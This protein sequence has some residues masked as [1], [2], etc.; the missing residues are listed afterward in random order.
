MLHVA[1]DR[2]IRLIILGKKTAH[3]FPAN[4]R[5]DG[6]IT[7]PKITPRKKHKVYRNAPFG[8]D[9]DPNVKPL[10]EVMI[11]KVHSDTLGDVTEEE[12]LEEGFASLDAFKIWWNRRWY[13]D[14]LNYRNHKI[15]PIWVIKFKFLRILPAGKELM[16]RLEE[17][18][19]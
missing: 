17:R 3:R 16:K 18:N 14:G 12:V 9:G 6:Q 13:H 4:Y 11:T 10:A 19:K 5:E 1:D 2:L 15:H 8:V 7:H